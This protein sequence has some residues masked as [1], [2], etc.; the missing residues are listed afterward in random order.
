MVLAGRRSAGKDEAIAELDL[1][2]LAK[3]CQE[4][5]QGHVF[6]RA[7]EE[8]C[9]GPEFAR[10]DVCERRGRD[11]LRV[12]GDEFHDFVPVDLFGGH[13]GSLPPAWRRGTERNL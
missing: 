6:R 4:L 9:A 2:P 10:H 8:P 12:F 13:V 5:W 11:A 1:V 7:G 3:E